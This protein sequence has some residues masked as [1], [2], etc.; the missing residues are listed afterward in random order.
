M[1]DR[2]WALGEGRRAKG[3]KGEN[4]GPVW[5]QARLGGRAAPGS[6]G[7]RLR[8]ALERGADHGL[9]RAWERSPEDFETLLGIPGVGAKTLRALSLV[10]EL[11]YGTTASTRD[12]ARF[13]FAHGG[14]DAHPFPVDRET[15]DRTIDVLA[16]AVKR[17]RVDD[18]E[19]VAALKRLSA[20]GAPALPQIRKSSETFQPGASSR[21]TRVSQE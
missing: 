16:A 10:S 18:S 12:P 1:G 5:F 4:A 11:V 8:L 3:R 6:G 9:W 7:A 21:A 17:A 19:K 13:S 2:R 20:F 14:K 15:Y